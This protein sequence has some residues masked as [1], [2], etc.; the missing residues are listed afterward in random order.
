M[1]RV[2]WATVRH[3]TGRSKSILRRLSLRQRAGHTNTDAH[4]D[5]SEIGENFGGENHATS[6]GEDTREEQPSTTAHRT[7]YVNIPVAKEDLDE[8]GTIK[9]TYPRNKVRTAKYTAL[10]FV[11]KNLWYQFHN[12]ANLYFL[13]LVILQVCPTV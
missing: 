6:G 8:E 13:L 10:S 9:R 7:I 2:R 3:P 11:P 4:P 5:L 1:A 12:V